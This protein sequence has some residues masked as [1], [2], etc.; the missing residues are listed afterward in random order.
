M[1]ICTL[2]LLAC[3]LRVAVGDLGLCCCV[4]VTSLGRQLT[5][6]FVDFWF[7]SAYRDWESKMDAL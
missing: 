5:S 2:H 1:Q 6:L 7:G 3:Q 4:Y